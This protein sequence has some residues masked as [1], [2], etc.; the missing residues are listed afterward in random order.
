MMVTGSCGEQ[1]GQRRR[2]REGRL[3]MRRALW[4]VKEREGVAKV[5]SEREGGRRLG[6]HI[7]SRTSEIYVFGQET[8]KSQFHFFF[9]NFAFLNNETFL[10][11]RAPSNLTVI[12]ILSLLSLSR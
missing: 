9:F 6:S 4:E 10:P 11:N 8:T 5:R 1:A 3:G 7:L 2:A 12:V